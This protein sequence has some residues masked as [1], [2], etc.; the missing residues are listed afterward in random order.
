MKSYSFLLDILIISFDRRTVLQNDCIERNAVKKGVKLGNCHIQLDVWLSIEK[1]TILKQNNS[2]SKTSLIFSDFKNIF[3]F[4][5]IQNK[6]PWFTQNSL[7]WWLPCTIMNSRDSSP[8]LSIFLF[9]FLSLDVFSF[10]FWSI[11]QFF[12]ILIMVSMC[13]LLLLRSY[14]VL[15]SMARDC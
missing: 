8:R 7:I 6:I 13:I 3:L 4:P 9:P 11:V 1:V 15:Q 2:N 12:F 14:H 5:L 10:S